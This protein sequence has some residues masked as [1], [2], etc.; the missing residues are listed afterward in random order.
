MPESKPTPETKA[1]TPQPNAPATGTPTP[2]RGQKAGTHGKTGRTQGFPGHWAQKAA[3]SSGKAADPQPKEGE[4]ISMRLRPAYFF[5]FLD[6]PFSVNRETQDYKELFDSIKENGVNE[7][8]K[9]RPRNGGGLELISGH[10]RHDVAEQLNYAKCTHCKR[11]L[12]EGIGTNKVHVTR[13][14]KIRNRSPI[15]LCFCFFDS[16]P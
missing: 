12:G 6:H 9:A 7:P 13:Q 16:C 15:L 5:Q 14:G 1:P 10:R 2:P 8:V 4:G 11:I 3:D